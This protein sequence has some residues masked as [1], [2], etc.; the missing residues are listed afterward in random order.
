M[1]DSVHKIF[2]DNAAVK[3]LCIMTTFI[4]LYEKWKSIQNS[5]YK[6]D[7]EKQMLRV[8]ESNLAMQQ[9]NLNLRQRLDRYVSPEIITV[10]VKKLIVV[11]ENLSK[12]AFF[13]EVKRLFYKE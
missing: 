11:Y 7:I 2:G 9:S 13:R 1:I 3:I 8:R 4:S 5:N 10:E 12:E 6:D